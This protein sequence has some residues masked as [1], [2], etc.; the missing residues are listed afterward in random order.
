MGWGFGLMAAK[1]EFYWQ[2]LKSSNLSGANKP[3]LKMFATFCP[4]FYSQ[5]FSDIQNLARKTLEVLHKTVKWFTEHEKILQWGKQTKTSWLFAKKKTMAL[6]DILTQKGYFEWAHFCTA[7]TAHRATRFFEYI[8][9]GKQ[10]TRKSP[11]SLGERSP[12]WKKSLKAKQPNPS[13]KSKQKS[14]KKVHFCGNIKRGFAF[15]CELSIMN[16]GKGT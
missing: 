10:Q 12:L 9:P 16:A 1:P 13:E 7:C 8:R 14:R 15:K 11:G 2:T 5:T 3:S 6:Q 4:T